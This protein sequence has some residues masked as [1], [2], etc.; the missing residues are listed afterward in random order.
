MPGDT[1]EA[2]YLTN[3]YVNATGGIDSNSGESPEQAKQT[4]AAALEYAVSGDVVHAAEGVYATGTMI[5]ST[6]AKSVSGSAP[7]PYIRARAV[8]PQGVLLVADGGLVRVA[9]DFRAVLSLEGHYRIDRGGRRGLR[10]EP[11]PHERREE[12]ENHDARPYDG[13]APE[14]L[15]G[16]EAFLPSRLWSA[17]FALAAIVFGVVFHWAKFLFSAQSPRP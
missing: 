8:V 1:L 15:H 3:W 5:Q 6:Y 10:R 16:V 14:A 13:R 2:V 4:L 7:N 17:A 12:D 11:H 9:V